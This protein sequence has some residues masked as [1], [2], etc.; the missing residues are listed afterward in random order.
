MKDDELTLRNAYRVRVEPGDVVVLSLKRPHPENALL[1][2]KRKLQ[3]AFPNNKTLISLPDA[4][5]IVFGPGSDGEWI[6]VAER[7]P[8]ESDDIVW[9]YD[10][11]WGVVCAYADGAGRWRWTIEDNRGPL[12]NVTHWL[13]IPRPGRPE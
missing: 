1:Y 11:A 7:M 4:E 6:G 2:A 9:C 12:N 10:Q 3:A 5:L 13:P 8:Q